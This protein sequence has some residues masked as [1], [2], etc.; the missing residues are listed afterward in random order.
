MWKKIRESERGG[1]EIWF[2]WKCKQGDS[3]DKKK[4][5]CTERRR[6]RHVDFK[7][8][9]LLLLIHSIWNMI[10][11]FKIFYI[12]FILKHFLIWMNEWCIYIALYCVLL[13]IQSASQS[14]G[15]VS[16]QPP[17]DIWSVEL[18]FFLLKLQGCFFWQNTI[19]VYLL[20]NV[21]ILTVIIII[22]NT[23]GIV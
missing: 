6:L 19:S 10:W 22:M 15:M 13:Y 1:G 7:M 12:C 23:F 9:L 8:L 3:A 14:C 20:H 5:I 18:P 21:L 11:L 4:K 16:S 17:P 2:L